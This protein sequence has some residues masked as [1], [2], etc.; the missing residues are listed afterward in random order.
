M[1]LGYVVYDTQEIIEKAYIGSQDY[2]Y[3]AL[4]LFVDFICVIVG[5]L[6]VMVYVVSWPS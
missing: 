1:F 4:T 6:I 3:H 5:I 2:V